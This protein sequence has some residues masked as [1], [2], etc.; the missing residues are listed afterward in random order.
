MARFSNF[1]KSEGLIMWST[2]L[3]RAENAGQRKIHINIKV[4]GNA[5]GDPKLV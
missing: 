1:V 3:W 2:K 4:S 5:A